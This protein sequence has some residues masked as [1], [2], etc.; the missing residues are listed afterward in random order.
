MAADSPSAAPRRKVV[1]VIARLNVGGP[2]L[3]AVLA[4]AGLRPQIDT[5]LAVGRGQV[6]EAA[7]LQEELPGRGRLPV[8]DFGEEEFPDA[9][10]G[11]RGRFVRAG[12]GG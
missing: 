10:L 4:T 2:A 8:E 7:G 6:P 9:G 3:H 12:G 1:R 5:T 11:V